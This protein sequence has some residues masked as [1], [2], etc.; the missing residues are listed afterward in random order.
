LMI[1]ARVIA[2]EGTHANHRNIDR[3]FATQT[4]APE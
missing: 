4:S 3:G 1:D 2:P